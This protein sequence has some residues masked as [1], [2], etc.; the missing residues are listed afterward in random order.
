MLRRTTRL[1]E[2]GQCIELTEDTDDRMTRTIASRECRLDPID[3]LLHREA[4]LLEHLLIV[5]RTLK[6]LQ[7]ELRM[8]PDVIRHT[9]K[10]ILMLL[11]KRKSSPLLI[12]HDETSL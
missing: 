3:T 10:Y 6:L 7:T 2:T 11:D 12:L 9:S 8:R 1:A 5:R 4:A